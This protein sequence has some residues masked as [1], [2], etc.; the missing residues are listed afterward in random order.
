MIEAL[1]RLQ[2]SDAKTVADMQLWLLQSKRTQG[3]DTPLN[4]VDAVS[5]F[6]GNDAKALT[7]A[8]GKP[9]VLKVDGKH[10]LVAKQKS[11]LGYVKASKEGNNMRTF[12]AEK[13]NGGT[14]WGAVYA[15]WMQPVEDVKSATAGMTVERMFFKDCTRH[16]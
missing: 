11:A 9:A 7:M 13:T 6:L 8:D 1:Q 16:S 5:A 10:L 2:P 15:Q 3:W 14:S 4:T 12:T